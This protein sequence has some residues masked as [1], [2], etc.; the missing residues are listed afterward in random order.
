MAERG[1]AVTA[2]T[3]IIGASHAGLQ[4]AVSLREM[5]DRSPITLVGA[6]IH[7]PYQRPPLSKDF[8]SGA[9]R[10]E[11]LAFR[12]PR[13]YSDQDITLLCGDPVA[14]ASVDGVGHG[15]GRARTASGRRLRFDRLALTVGAR[16][17]R[18]RVPG[19]DLYGIHY[20]RDLGDAGR[21]R[22]ALTGAS[23]VVVVGGGFVGL[24]V[25]GVARA[26]GRVVTVVEATG[27]LM[28]RAVSPIVSDFYRSAHER[29]GTTVLLES[30]VTAFRGDAR[31]RVCGV[32]LDDG[33]ELPADLVVVGVGAVPRTELAEG[34]GLECDGGIVVDARAR[35]SLRD[36]VAAG[37]CTV[38][39][40]PQSG[41]VRVHLE[42]VSNAVAQATV[43][44]ATLVGAPDGAPRVPWF[45]SHQGDLRLQMAGL[46]RSSDDQV[47]R[48]EPDTERFSV[49]YYREGRL[50]AVH[51][52]N[53]PADF[54]AVRKA[55]LQRRSIPARAAANGSASLKALLAAAL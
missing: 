23:R 52:V 44:A 38:L 37:D 8:L 55:L 32:L 9:A 51:A 53:Q 11:T 13:F 3:L 15:A 26:Q 24:E 2:G 42:S 36:V 7:P 41:D 54:M 12:T 29:R 28:T 16:P 17:R 18:L 1:V 47:V 40:D 31:R 48:G 25:A 14:E 27:G 20:L 34:L 33:R 46:A 50:V 21:L 49:L 39:P 35:T 5:G 10:A 4:L 30:V 6:E 22:T 45:W 19:T 43:A